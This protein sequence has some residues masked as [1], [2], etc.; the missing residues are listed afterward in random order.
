[1]RAW[2]LDTR[3]LKHTHTQTHAHTH[4][5]TPTPDTHTDTHAHTHSSRDTCTHTHACTHTHTHPKVY[6]RALAQYT[7]HKFTH[8][9]EKARSRYRYF[10][11]VLSRRQQCWVGSSETSTSGRSQQRGATATNYFLS[12]QQPSVLFQQHSTGN[13][14]QL[15]QHSC[16]ARASNSCLE[17]GYSA[18][19]AAAQKMIVADRGTTLARPS[20][21]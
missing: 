2:T 10:T 6:R 5:H 7:I 8:H 18:C 4:T 9:R 17:I 15:S 13:K 3:A 21:C 12:P 14:P 11:F 20:R 19:R 1:M 16:L